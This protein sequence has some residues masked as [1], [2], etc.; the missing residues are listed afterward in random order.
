MAKEPGPQWLPASAAEAR[1]LAYWGQWFALLFGVIFLVIGVM[2]L[3]LWAWVG[4]IYLVMS[5]VINIVA[6]LMLKT[7]F[8]DSI[9]A[10][11]F[12]EGS[13]RLII[14]SIITLIFGIISG[15]F[16]LLSWVKLGEVFQPNYQP[17]PSGQ[18]QA[19]QP[20][21]PQAPAAPAPAPQA[22]PQ[23]A[24]P[25]PAPQPAQ[26][27]AQDQ[28]KAEMVKC[29]KCGVQYPAFMRTCPNCNEPR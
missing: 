14:W 4:P 27:P 19:G 12:K 26:Q 25:Q 7:S 15:V 5:G 18:Y 20:Q 28:K 29:K 11:R 21:A 3:I 17:Y 13:E 6:A 8:F 9:D 1:L 24:A 10:G 2:G 16:L 23:P 22:P